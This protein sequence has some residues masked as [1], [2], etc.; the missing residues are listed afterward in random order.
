MRAMVLHGHGG[1]DALVHETNFPDPECG[2]NDVIVRVRSTSLNYHD[3][4]TRNGMPG[5]KIEM[6]MI[7]GLDVAGDIAEIGT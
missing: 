7:C 3:I 1:P 2:P 5:I 6:P 4:F